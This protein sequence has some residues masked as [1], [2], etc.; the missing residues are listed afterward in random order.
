MNTN[1][2]TGHISYTYRGGR[3]G[4]QYHV[5]FIRLSGKWIEDAGF[6]IGDTFEITIHKSRLTIS[7]FKTNNAE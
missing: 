1:K 3:W 7:K 4:D 2:H 5:P 6:Q